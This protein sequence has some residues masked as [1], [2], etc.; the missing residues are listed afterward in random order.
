MDGTKLLAKG[1]DRNLGGTAAG[2]VQQIS[3]GKPMKV[4][5]VRMTR[6]YSAIG[7]QTVIGNVVWAKGALPFNKKSRCTG[8]NFSMSESEIKK[9]TRS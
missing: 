3:G 6:V 9:F 5:A 1:S 4:K 8:Q 7:W 2:T